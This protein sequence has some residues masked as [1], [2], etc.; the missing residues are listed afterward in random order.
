MQPGQQRDSDDAGGTVTRLLAEVEKGNA[1]ALDALFPVVYE[2]LRAIARR[3]RRDWDGDT[4]IGT[5]ALVNETYLKLTG[6]CQIHATSRLHFLRVASRAMRQIL[7]NY[8]RD[9]RTMKRGGSLLHVPLDLIDEKAG[10]ETSDIESIANLEDALRKLELREPRLA[11]VVEC[12]FYGG[13]SVEDTAA[14]LGISAA[15]VKR[16]W[17]LARAWLY[18]ELTEG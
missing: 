11:E 18:R 13:M 10:R 17:S 4:T 9:R 12:R 3:H 7:S 15:T 1:S 2:E 8:A 14:A 16:D 6:V 5:T